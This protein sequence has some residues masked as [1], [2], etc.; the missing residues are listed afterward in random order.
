MPVQTPLL[1]LA[2]TALAKGP[3]ATTGSEASGASSE[4]VVLSAQ[5][6]GELSASGIE[7]AYT[8]S[9]VLGESAAIVLADEL[10]ESGALLDLAAEV[11]AGDFEVD[12]R[13]IVAG[14]APDLA[15]ASGEEAGE[16]IE[17]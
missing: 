5:A 13:V 6:A 11:S 16:A 17:P 14:P 7:I 3:A 4:A 15:V 9:A 8:G 2:M 1:A 10:A 12:D